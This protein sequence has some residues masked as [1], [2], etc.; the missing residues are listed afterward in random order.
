MPRRQYGRGVEN[1][2]QNPKMR[3]GENPTLTT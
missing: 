2:L 3:K 1:I